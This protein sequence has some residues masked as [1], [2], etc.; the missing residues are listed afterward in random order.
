MLIYGTL[1]NEPMVLDQ[2]LLI[3]GNKRVE[4]FWLSEWVRRQGVIGMLRLFRQVRRLMRAGILTT[5]VGSSYSLDQ[6]KEAV[7]QAELPGR[8]GKV[9]L[10]VTEGSQ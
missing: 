8:R 4:G 9:L 1:S 3:V 10:R 6:I 7:R 2:R 5:E